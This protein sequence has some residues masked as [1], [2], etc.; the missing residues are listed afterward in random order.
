MEPVARISN[1]GEL[2]VKRGSR[3]IKQH[4]PFTEKVCGDWCPRFDDT[5]MKRGLFTCDTWW[6]NTTDGRPED[7]D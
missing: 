4:C 5:D 6:R 2:F 7:S 3:W 1:T